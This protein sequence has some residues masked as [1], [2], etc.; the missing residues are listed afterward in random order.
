MAE[1]LFA[2]ITTHITMIS[3]S[4]YLHRGLAHRGLSFHPAVEHFF[5]FWVWLTTGMHA[6]QWVAIHRK[7]HRFPD[8]P[9]DPHSP[10]E[11]GLWSMIFGKG[12]D[13]Y[14][15][16]GRDANL[17]MTYGAGCPRDKIER[18]LYTPYFM[19]GPLLLLVIDVLLF[20]WWGIAIWLWQ[21]IWM[22]FFGAGILGGL[23]HWWG[24]KHAEPKDGSY[25]VNCTPIG[26]F[27]AGEELHNN[28]HC[29]PGNPKFS[30][31]WYEFDVSW[32]WFKILN[33]F[34]LAWVNSGPKEQFKL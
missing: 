16:A 15:S 21:K 23:S 28:H 30:R 26:I 8:K 17:V 22:P 27:L 32:M 11:F 10:H 18:V 33:F 24:Y 3:V 7:H 34:G 20:G 14:M 12:A 13:T 19:Q 2:L 5:R 9:G 4:L 1:L 31:K 25:A 29:E 6:R